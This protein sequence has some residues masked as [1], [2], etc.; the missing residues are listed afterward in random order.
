M[1]THGELPNTWLKRFE[2]EIS[3]A[4]DRQYANGRQQIEVKVSIQAVLGAELTQEQIDSVRIVEVTSDGVFVPLTTASVPNGWWL[5]TQKNEYD[6][7]PTTQQM[8]VKGSEQDSSL[9]PQAEPVHERNFYPVTLAPGGSKK[10]L[11]ARITKDG[12]NEYITNATFISDVTLTAVAPPRFSA[13]SDYVFDRVLVSGS[14]NSGIF[15]YEFQLYP[16]NTTIKSVIMYPE[17]MIQWDDK[18]SEEFHASYV[19]YAGPAEANFRFNEEIVTGPYFERVTLVSHNNPGKMTVLLQGAIN[20]P[21]HSASANT[22]NGPC[23]IS[24]IDANGNEHLL[25]IRFKGEMGFENR[26]ELTLMD[27]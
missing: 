1:I 17:G 2:I 7:F 3:S 5:T 19:G 8:T 11:W 20:I 14:E 24:A 27:A 12:D 16:I 9:S 13:I 10:K 6:Y 21:Y 25:K 15:V 18:S 22:W 26:T 4:S 23:G